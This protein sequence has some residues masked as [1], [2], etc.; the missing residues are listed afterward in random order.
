M[1]FADWSIEVASKWNER[2]CLQYGWRLW[3]IEVR[4][5][6]VTGR[7]DA[8]PHHIVKT[9]SGYTVNMGLWGDKENVGVTHEVGHMLG[10]KDEYYTVDDVSY[11][12]SERRPRN[13]TEPLAQRRGESVINNPKSAALAEHF[14]LIQKAAETEL[15]LAQ[16]STVLV[17][18]EKAYE[19]RLLR[20]REER[21]SL[22][23]KAAK[24]R[25]RSHSSKFG[26]VLSI[27]LDRTR[28]QMREEKKQK[29]REVIA[30]KATNMPA[31]YEKLLNRFSSLF[32]NL[33]WSA[34]QLIEEETEGKFTPFTGIMV[35]N[36]P[37]IAQN[38]GLK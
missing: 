24:G 17:P 12:R 35:E 3:P 4:I 38:T 26:S 32:G 25:L 28:L 18:Y 13:K 6:N 16:D 34:Y 22:K 5:V 11:S 36:Y 30:N 7:Q 20:E 15:H 9:Q 8:T 1:L 19:M 21:L 31:V 2:F 14:H 23:V 29:R 33:I 10:N 37:E 27:Y